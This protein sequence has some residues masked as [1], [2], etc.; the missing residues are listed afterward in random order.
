M[1]IKELPY[2]RWWLSSVYLLWNQK[3][4]IS[5]LLKLL[6]TKTSKWPNK[7]NIRLCSYCPLFEIYWYTKAY[8]H[9][10]I[11]KT[12]PGLMLSI[13]RSIKI[14]FIPIPNPELLGFVNLNVIPRTL[15][16]YSSFLCLWYCI[17]SWDTNCTPLPD[18]LLHTFGWTLL[19]Y[20]AL[21]LYLI[22]I[23]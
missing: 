17:L 13:M 2:N 11:L 23:V 8:F 5:I 4:Y 9:K 16:M 1:L 12:H 14:S 10:K 20:E 19:S 22:F 3:R 7:E 18:E 21:L 15:A 6:S